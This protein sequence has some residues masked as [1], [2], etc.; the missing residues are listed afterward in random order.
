MPLNLVNDSWIPAVRHG[1]PVTIRP[2]EIAAEGV[3][4]LDW[5]RDDLNLAGLE[6][7]IGLVYLADPPRND[8]DW[9]HRYGRPDPNRLHEA[10]APLSS[11]FELTGDG[12][13]FL[14]DIETFEVGA[15]KG[16]IKS[17]EMLFVDSAGGQTKTHNKDIMVKRDRYGPLPLPLAAM[18]LYTLQAF[19]PSG[20]SG[21]RTSMRG[22][23]PMVTLMKPV[24]GGSHPLWRFVWLNVPDG[25]PLGPGRAAEALPW[26]RPTRT[27][28]NDEAVTPDMSHPGERFFGMPRRL[29]LIFEGRRATGVVQQPRGT[30]YPSEHWEHPLS[31]YY[32][33]E[34][35]GK[36]L[37]AHPRP[38][39][40]SYPNWLGQTFGQP[41]ETGGFVAQTVQRY[42]NRMDPPPAETCA[43]GWSMRNATP[44]DFSLHTYPTFKTDNDSEL[45]VSAL[46]TAANEAAKRLMGAL[47]GSLGLEGRPVTD[48]RESFFTNTESRFV[49]AVHAV[50]AEK[51]QATEEAWTKDLR[52]GALSL[53]DQLTASGLSDRDLAGIEKTVLARRN[54]IGFFAPTAKK[55]IRDILDLPPVLDEAPT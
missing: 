25:A 22:G 26:L 44:A 49:D 50:V 27:S 17:P 24:D 1:K 51:D 47:K 12:P 10:L 6:L 43:G 16:G 28:K 40:I 52:R 48:A 55:G 15:K 45:R 5:P 23:G 41:G 46:V 53:F 34:V 4:R 21:N 37:P 33:T 54:L 39:K 38:G 20:G 13:R 18:A 7:L 35:G 29:R 2:S 32:S 30:N 36:R 9:E 8:S 14:Q 19:A 3:E 42:H 11:F 31:P